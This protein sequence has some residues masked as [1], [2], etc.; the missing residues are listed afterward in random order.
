MKYLKLDIQKFAI[1]AS[2]SNDGLRSTS[3]PQNK[4]TVTA[5]F[6]ENSTSTTGNTSSITVTAT[7]TQNT[8]SYAQISTPRI[9]VWWCD[10][11]GYATA[12]R[13]AY[14]EAKAMNRNDTV[15]ATATFNVSHKSDGS[16][17]GY[18]IGKW[19]YDGG[20]AWPCKSGSTQT[21]NTALTKIPRSCTIKATNAYIGKTSTI[22][23]SGLYTGLTAKVTYVNN[24]GA[25]V[26]AATLNGTSNGTATA[27]WTIPTEF[28][29]RIPSSKSGT[30]SITATTYSGSTAIGSTSSTNV[31]YSIDET[32]SDLKPT[33][34]VTA[35]EVN[36]D[37]RK[38]TVEPDGTNN[39]VMY[40]RSTIYCEAYAPQVF[41]G[42]Q[43]SSVTLNGTPI[44]MLTPYIDFVEAN[45]NI[46]TATIKDSRGYT[47]S[48]TVT[49]TPV[50][51]TNLTVSASVV[52][53]KSR[54][55]KVKLSVSG[56]WSETKFSSVNTNTLALTYKYKEQGGS[57]YTE[58]TIANS[59]LTINSKTKTYE[60][61]NPIVLEGF[62]PAKAYVF[63]VYATDVFG[64][65]PKQKVEYVVKKGESPFFIG[66]DNNVY[67]QGK[68]YRN[69]STG[70][71]EAGGDSLPIGT[72]VD[73]D[74]TAVPEGYEAVSG[75]GGAEA[76]WPVG[77]IYMNLLDN[78]NPKLILGFGEWIQITN[79]FIYASTT[80]NNTGGS[81]ALQQH[82]HSIPSLSGTAYSAGGH[83]HKYYLPPSWS[84]KIGT[85][86][87]N[88]VTDEA[89]S[90]L[91]A[92]YN[93]STDGAHTHSVATN[94]STT[95]VTGSGAAASSGEG[96]MP[97][98]LTA[99][100][101]YRKS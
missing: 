73:Y 88:T 6:I 31:T 75:A 90:G 43:L 70:R 97:P 100:M 47:G 39:K 32:V 38:L 29:N 48:S 21:A 30:V 74:G 82:S 50:D 10:N 35:Y 34:K 93:T 68:I 91:T 45:T 17:S 13:M 79:R 24:A 44:S 86:T 66:G 83:S 69:T 3:S 1:S 101:W 42:A 41:K 85:G 51:Y 60:T 81:A 18:A 8:G 37:I 25:T 16:L 94:A 33:I 12:T 99:Y 95:G 87:K 54:D 22:T 9:E 15:T 89:G 96:N 27:S 71:V 58:G 46:Y 5:Y 98:Y 14:T 40:G 52:R 53:N 78:R 63:E 23:A 56:N 2:A 67:I 59:L 84:F 36:Q 65:I 26:T 57:T 28:Y 55:G 11:N 76:A 80:A 19:V 20:S 4:G 92:T 7:Y 64:T 77:S 49:L 72:I 62:D 61:T